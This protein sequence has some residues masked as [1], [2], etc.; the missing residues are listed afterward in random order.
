MGL[1]ENKRDMVPAFLTHTLLVICTLI[2]SKIPLKFLLLS[3]ENREC[4]K[5]GN[6][7]VWYGTVWCGK[8]MP[9]EREG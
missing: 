5:V 9:K 1:A 7:T 4:K 2:F 6:D 8:I 3:V